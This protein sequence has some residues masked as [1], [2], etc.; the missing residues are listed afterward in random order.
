MKTAPDTHFDPCHAWAMPS[1][2]S[3]GRNSF[4]ELRFDFRTSTITGR[5]QRSENADLDRRIRNVRQELKRIPASEVLIPHAEL[6]S[7]VRADEAPNIFDSL[8]ALAVFA[9]VEEQS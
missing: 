9:R 2:L 1:S 6:R 8:L 5:Q 4:F 7:G 3:E